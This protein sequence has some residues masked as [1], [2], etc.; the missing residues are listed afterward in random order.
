[1]GPFRLHRLGPSSTEVGSFWCFS[2]RLSWRS[3]MLLRRLGLGHGIDWSHVAIPLRVSHCVLHWLCRFYSIK[4][5]NEPG[6]LEIFLDSGRFLFPPL[7]SLFCEL[8]LFPVTKIVKKECS[9]RKFYLKKITLFKDY[10]LAFEIENNEAVEN[11]FPK[12]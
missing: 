3:S 12:K 5:I 2:S 10:L 7:P 1:M 11:I 6:F 9:E 4:L 8:R